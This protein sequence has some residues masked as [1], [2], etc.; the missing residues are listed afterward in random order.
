MSSAATSLVY[1]GTRSL[2]NFAIEVGEI[3]AMGSNHARVG[4]TLENWSQMIAMFFTVRA[5]RSRVL[6]EDAVIFKTK[7]V[8]GI[9]Q[10][11]TAGLLTTF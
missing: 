1:A 3:P 9:R 5:P 10:A 6:L 7:Q 8:S 4:A 2:V 11:V